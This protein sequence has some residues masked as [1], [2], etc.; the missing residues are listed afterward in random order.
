MQERG[1][2]LE[3]T[4]LLRELR[5]VEAQLVAVEERL[6]RYLHNV[7]VA[8]SHIASASGAPWQTQSVVDYGARYLSWPKPNL[9][10]DEAARGAAVGAVSPSGSIGRQSEHVDYM[11]PHPP[12]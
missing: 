4:T 3:L 6:S 11:R 7:G 10:S 1:T 9:R 8:D 12:V 2:D 5:Q